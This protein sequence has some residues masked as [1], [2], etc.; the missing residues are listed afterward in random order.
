MKPQ[1]TFSRPS[2]PHPL[3]L[4]MIRHKWESMLARGETVG[5]A[6]HHALYFVLDYFL[7]KPWLDTHVLFECTHPGYAAMKPV[8]VDDQ[9]GVDKAHTQR[10][11]ELAETLF[12][13]QETPGLDYVIDRIMSGQIESAVAELD[14]G[15][16]MRIQGTQFSYRGETGVKGQDYDVDLVYPDGTPAGCDIKCKLDG[17]AFS[18][19]GLLNALKAAKTQIPEDLP[20]VAFVKIPQEWVNRETG[21]IGAGDAVHRALEE[22]FRNT[23]R[24]VLVAIYCKLTTEV[25]TG[26]QINHV[27]RQWENAATKFPRDGS[28]DLFDPG[29]QVPGWANLSVVL[30][31]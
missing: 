1:G 3:T 23:N 12:N 17:S 16:F 2:R 5:T 11:L 29:R 30:R 10:A 25:A 7:G 6:T 4:D 18:K 24:M 20:G 21:E 22:F 31:M 28:W 27:C 13:L 14:F 8:M 26:T 19:N 15:M 9:Y